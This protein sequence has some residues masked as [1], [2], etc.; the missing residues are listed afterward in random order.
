[1]S[2]P[3]E[4][5]VFDTDQRA[6]IGTPEAVSFSLA[7]NIEKW[8]TLELYIK[9]SDPVLKNRSPE[10][11]NDYRLSLYRSPDGERQPK[12]E[13]IFLVVAANYA[14]GNT[15]R[16]LAYSAEHLLTRRRV[17]L[18]ATTPTKTDTIDNLMKW[19]VRNNN[20]PDA[21]TR[22]QS[23]ITVEPDTSRGAT[24]TGW[25]VPYDSTEVFDA[26]NDLRKSSKAQ[27]TEIFFRMLTTT[28]GYLFKT[29]AG[30]VGADRRFVTGS[31]PIVLSERVGNFKIG[32]AG[33]DA[34]DEKN[35]ITVTGGVGPATLADATA[36]SRSL[37]ALKETG[38]SG[39]YGD[40]DSAAE[41]VCYTELAANKARKVF[42]GN[43]IETPQFLYGVH[44]FL[45]DIF[46][47]EHKNAVY[48]VMVRA[49][50]LAKSENGR[51][52][53]DVR[54]EAV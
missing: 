39:G 49:V 54:V 40:D 53:I 25:E 18:D 4:Y 30:Y 29:Y 20:G 16:M 34:A 9:D 47:A 36:A 24:I 38:R 14:D 35:S 52:R 26:L 42:S 17:R 46:T 48:T 22:A 7:R 13:N 11:L 5:V 45:G 33:Y 10:S 2:D 8:D 28:A 32:K 50:A 51:R 6:R 43:I 19:L 21:G 23:G 27:G 15:F 41:A 1:M 44:W 12:L 31:N 37:Y 3:K